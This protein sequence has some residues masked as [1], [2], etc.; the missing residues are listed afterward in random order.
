MSYGLVSI[1]IHGCMQKCGKG[2]TDLGYLKKGAHLK[3]ASGK[4]KL[5]ML[6]GGEIDTRGDECPRPLN[7]PLYMCVCMYLCVCNGTSDGIIG[8]CVMYDGVVCVI[9][10]GASRVCV[11]SA[12]MMSGVCVP[13]AA[14]TGVC[15]AVHYLVLH[16]TLEEILETPE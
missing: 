4:K 5:V 12:T 7:T 10:R 15:V 16:G 8:V 11:M 13:S 1:Y 9:C 6:R 2:G 3:A 14:V